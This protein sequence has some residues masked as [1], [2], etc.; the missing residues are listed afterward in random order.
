MALPAIPD[1][2]LVEILLRLPTP[3]DL[4][5]ASA[6]CVSF[7]RL[8]AD[9]AFLRRFRKLHPAPL[10]GFLDYK[11]FH[12]AV[13]P[14]PSARAASA[15][16]SAADFDFTF[17]P[18]P[19]WGWTV[20][21]VRDGRVLLDRPCRHDEFGPL[22]KEMVVCDPL[23]RRYLLLPPIPDDL[24][25]PAV[26]QILIERDCFADCFL[27][28]SGD[29]EEAEAMEEETS[30]RV[31]WLVLLQTKRAVL[32]FSSSTGQWRAITSLTCSLP[33]FVLSTWTLLSVSRHYAH[34]CFYWIS[35]LSEKLLVLDIR[36]MEFSMPDHPPCVR[37][38]RG[39]V[40]IVEAGQGVTVMFVPKPDTSRRVYTVWRNNGWS[41]T[42]WQMENEAFS[43]DSGSFM[44]GAVGRHLLLHYGMI[45]SVKTGCYTRDVNTL[46]LARVCDS[47]P[48]QSEAYCNFPRSLL[49][50]PTVSSG[51]HTYYRALHSC[52]G[53]CMTKLNFTTII[54]KEVACRTLLNFSH[55][56]PTTEEWTTLCRHQ[57]HDN[58]TLEA[59]KDLPVK[60]RRTSPGNCRAS[61]VVSAAARAPEPVEAGRDGRGEGG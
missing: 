20:R 51:Q 13:P 28:P 57:N 19:Y 4:I 40:A 42:Q 11:G 30:F 21:E 29:E 8:V 44:I 38:L 22:F 14:H 35:G 32:A 48:H 45:S 15:V 23:H 41:S 1:E 52:P 56:T 27:A 43:L 24:A 58:L 39:D 37:V 6:A 55:A 12:P 34:G 36:R 47:C 10:L 18:A 60:N 49:S 61:A 25:A 3:E 9:R 33:G 54:N 46:Q 26:C 5:R 7:R 31:F 53:C 2:L 50:S 16:A 59:W 17:L